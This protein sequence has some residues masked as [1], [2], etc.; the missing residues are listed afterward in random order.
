MSV[1]GHHLSCTPIILLWSLLTP[2]TWAYDMT[3]TFCKCFFFSYFRHYVITAVED[4]FDEEKMRKMSEQQIKASEKVSHFTHTHSCSLLL[5][6]SLHSFS[7][8]LTLTLTLTVS[9]TP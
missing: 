8:A 1:T 6:F 3:L 9:V 4:A 7:F 2:V 5:S